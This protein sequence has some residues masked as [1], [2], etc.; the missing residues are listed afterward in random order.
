MKNKSKFCVICEKEFI[1]DVKSRQVCYDARCLKIY[2]FN[3]GISNRYWAKQCY[4]CHECKLTQVTRKFCGKNCSGK[5]HSM[6]CLIKQT[7]EGD[8]QKMQL[9][10]KERQILK[11]QVCKDF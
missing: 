6:R 10:L 3:M 4:W 1:P 5:Y 2:T 7:F 8:L 9:S 11:L